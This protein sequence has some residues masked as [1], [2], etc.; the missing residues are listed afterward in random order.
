[1]GS[2]AHRQ[3]LPKR[4]GRAVREGRA[5]AAG[6]YSGHPAAALRQALVAD[7]VDAPVNAMEATRTKPPVDRLATKTEPDQLSMANHAMLARGDRGHPGIRRAI[8][9][10]VSHSEYKCRNGPNSPPLSSR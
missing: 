10:F 5:F 3:D 6:E 9:L 1:M 2:A 7:G 4:C 8:L